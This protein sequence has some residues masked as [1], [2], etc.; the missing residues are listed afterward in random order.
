MSEENEVSSLGALEDAFGQMFKS[1][2]QDY[3]EDL[4]LYVAHRGQQK[5]LTPNQLS[6]LRIRLA[7]RKILLRC[8]TLIGEKKNAI[9]AYLMEKIKRG[10]TTPLVPNQ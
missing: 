6:A 2:P 4:T 7:D 8:A 10:E 3:R 9:A 1:Y 5:E